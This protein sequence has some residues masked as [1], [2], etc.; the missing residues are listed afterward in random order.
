M[1]VK[2]FRL[3]SCGAVLVASLALVASASALPGSRS[4]DEVYP[5]ASALC[6]KAQAGTLPRKLEASQAQVQAACA[7]LTNPFAPLTSTVQQAETTYA[8]TVAAEA[9]K[10]AAVCPPPRGFAARA[11]CRE[12][13]LSRRLTDSTALLTR[14]VAVVTYIS[15]LEANRVTFW[16]TI[17]SLRG[18][19]GL[20]SDPPITQPTPQQNPS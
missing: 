17:H 1:F 4:F 12:A 9:Q 15:A 16:A 5:Y 19:S 7:T 20:K 18:G 6:V 8:D 11:S 10:V 2:S 3:V 14:H 13:R